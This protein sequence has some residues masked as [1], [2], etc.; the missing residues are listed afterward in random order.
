MVDHFGAKALINPVGGFRKQEGLQAAEH[1]LQDGDNHKGNAQHLKRVEAALADHLVDNH[2]DQQGVGQGEELNHEARGQNLEQHT[3]VP[4]QGR[5]KP[6]RTELLIR[7]G[8]G[9]L[10]QQQLNPL[11]KLIS[12][13]I[14]RK[15]H[16]ALLGRSELEALLIAGNHQSEAPL[17]GQH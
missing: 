1:P 7:G 14:R 15:R 16:H 8:I 2:L 17:P 12:Q 13:V 10:H 5:P 6:P 9:P 11:W 4:L 3:S